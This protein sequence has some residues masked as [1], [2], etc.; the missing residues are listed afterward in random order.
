MSE[1]HVFPWWAGYFLLNPVRKVSLNPDIILKSYIKPGMKIIDAGCAMGFFSLPLARLTGSSGKVISIDPQK[2]MLS[3]LKKRAMKAG[4][5]DIIDARLC[6]F[7]SLMINDLRGQADIA[8]TFGVL[9]EVQDNDRFIMELASALKKNGIFFIG[10]PH[11][12]STEEFNTTVK[13]AID[14]GFG[15]EGVTIKGK[16]KIA[17]LRKS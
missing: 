9:H 4:L 5:S 10:E 8:L 13:R 2:R 1:R 7:N 12:V 17:V 16:N 15:L 11:V 3:A 6:T 14:H